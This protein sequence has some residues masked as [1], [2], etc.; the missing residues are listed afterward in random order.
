ML[1]TTESQSLEVCGSLFGEK[2]F[3]FISIPF[4]MFD[5]KEMFKQIQIILRIFLFS[6]MLRKTNFLCISV[7]IS[8]I[9][10]FIPKK[11][12]SL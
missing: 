9:V 5:Q 6:N 11:K 1:K 12:C 2:Q 7:L 10:T 4:Y 8:T 3:W